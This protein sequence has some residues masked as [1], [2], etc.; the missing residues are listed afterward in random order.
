[1]TFGRGPSLP[2]YIKFFLKLKIHDRYRKRLHMFR[3]LLLHG[4]V[5]LKKRGEKCL[6]PI[7]LLL[8]IVLRCK[9]TFFVTL[10]ECREN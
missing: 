3:K 5:F 8:I 9:I 6:K 2:P 1:M 10:R 7:A 4:T